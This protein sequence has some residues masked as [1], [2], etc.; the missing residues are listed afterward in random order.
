MSSKEDTLLAAIE[1]HKFQTTNEGLYTE[2]LP[3]IIYSTA[4]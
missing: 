4:R 2:M 1:L 3:D